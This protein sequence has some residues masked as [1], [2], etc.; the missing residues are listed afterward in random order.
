MGK[1]SGDFTTTYGPWALVTGASD[2][3]GAAFATELAARGLSLMLVAR[4]EDRLQAVAEKLRAAHRVDIRVI[5]ADLG[6]EA[7][8]ETVLAAADASEIG[9]YVGAAGFGTAGPFVRNS[10]VLELNMIDVN[11]RALCALAHQ[12]ARSMQARGKGGIV[13]MSSIV[14]FQGVRNSANYAATKAYVQ[15][16]A[17]GLAAE[18]QPFGVSVLASAPGPVAT[19]FAARAD[20]KM[21]NAASPQDVSRASLAALGPG[22]TV[23]PGG[24]PSFWVMGLACCRAA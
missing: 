17:E 22:G 21:G 14:A 20:M 1:A 2:G 4:R 10:G 19:G 15:T 12:M 18:L 8:I 16:L 23:R 9:L 6:T 7:G 24:W 3:I 11:C 13:L 5:A